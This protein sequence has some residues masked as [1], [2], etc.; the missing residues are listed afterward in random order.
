[1]VKPFQAE[2]VGP[3]DPHFVVVLT[4][5]QRMALLDLILMSITGPARLE[6]YVDV[7]RGTETRP[8]ELLEL[9]MNAGQ[10]VG[11]A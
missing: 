9:V 7:L 2:R 10:E 4:P 3:R 1:M 11:R 8:D 6:V 5:S